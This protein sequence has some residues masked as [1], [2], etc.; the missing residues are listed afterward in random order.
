M[1]HGQL[2]LSALPAWA[3]L[4]DVDFYDVRVQ[5]LPGRGHGLATTRSLSSEEIFD[6]PTLLSIPQNMILS[7]EAIEEHT[8]TDKHFRELRRVAAFTVC[9]N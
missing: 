6:S 2:P 8:R 7:A 4:N 5:Y 9:L 3:K 1:R